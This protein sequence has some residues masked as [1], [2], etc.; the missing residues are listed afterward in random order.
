MGAISGGSSQATFCDDTAGLESLPIASLHTGDLAY[1]RSKEITPEGPFFFLNKAAVFPAGDAVIVPDN[2]ID[3]EGRWLSL[4]VFAFPAVPQT[5]FGLDLYPS[6]TPVSIIASIIPP[7]VATTF[8][9]KVTEAFD[10]SPFI[11]L[12]LASG[13]SEVFAPHQVRLDI[14]GTYTS[15][16]VLVPT[17]P[18]FVRLLFNQGGATAGKARVTL[19]R[20]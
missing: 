8:S 20:G 14:V 18:D 13:P 12:G 3:S 2:C 4:V 17:G 7:L 11:F 5:V 19:I 9:V 10:G 15:A 16:E 1:I 6:T